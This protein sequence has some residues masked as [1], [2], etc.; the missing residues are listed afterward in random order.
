MHAC[1][2][3]AAALAGLPLFLPASHHPCGLCCPGPFPL[4][5][6]QLAV[7][8]L[9]YGLA[10]LAGRTAL[11]SSRR[12]AQLAPV[13]ARLM[14]FPRSAASAVAG[15]AATALLDSRDVQQA[16]G[17]AAAEAAEAR[18][19]AALAGSG[20]SDVAEKAR[21]AAYAAAMSA[22]LRLL[23]CSLAAAAQDLQ[24]AR[25]GAGSGAASAA[26]VASA[27]ARLH[28]IFLGE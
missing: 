27:Q 18:L 22:R 23:R 26:D 11:A 13:L 7:Q 12:G 6:I 2:P 15:G 28:S 25:L 3:E 8:E 21:R 1:L 17:D 24:A 14:A 16:V 9:R 4:Q 20:G 19:G 10:L 5:P